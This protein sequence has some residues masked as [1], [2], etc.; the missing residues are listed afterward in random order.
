MYDIT[1]DNESWLYHYDPETKC[2]SQGWVA[3]NDPRPTKVRRKRCVDKHMF[4]IFLMKS[5]F[6]SIIFLANSKTVAAK[7]YANEHISNVLKQVEKDRHL[8]SL[9]IHHDGPSV[10]RAAQTQMFNTLS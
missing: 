1:T 7:C 9:I 8:K 6:N 3:S 10:H 2:Q 5:D 4:A